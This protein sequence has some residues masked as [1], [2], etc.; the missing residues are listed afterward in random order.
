MGVKKSTEVRVVDKKTG[1]EKGSKI[2]RY[3][4]LPVDALRQVAEHFGIG[5]EKYSIHNWRYKYDWS[6][7]YA[8]LQRHANL[9]WDG[10]DIDPESGTNHMAAVVFHALALI[11]YCDT[12]RDKDDR[13]KPD[14]V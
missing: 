8:A 5:A 4:L 10:E 13:W 1:A 12:N 11:E 7:S 14:E 9:F 6:L 3:D 2:E